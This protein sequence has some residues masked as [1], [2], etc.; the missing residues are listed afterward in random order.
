[1]ALANARDAA[2]HALF[3]GETAGDAYTL[4][5]AGNA[6][7]IGTADAGDLPLGDGQSVRRGLTGPE[8]LNFSVNGNPTDLMAVIKTLSE[9]LRAR[10]P[11]RPQA[12][13]DALDALDAGSRQGH[14]RA[15]RWSARALPG[16]TSPPTGRIDLS[17][18]RRARK[19]TSAA[20]TSPPPSPSCSR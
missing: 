12:A 3:G 14:H 20:P 19:Q 4:D 16:S 5:G 1:M 2:G 10:R 6:A 15:D 18:L 11:I 9:A 13:R 8:F 17:E 7:Y